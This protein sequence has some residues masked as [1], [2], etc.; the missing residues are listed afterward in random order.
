[1]LLFFLAVNQ[2]CAAEGEICANL[3]V[4]ESVDEQGQHQEV[5]DI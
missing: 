3:Q 4:E 1:M 5:L 2:I